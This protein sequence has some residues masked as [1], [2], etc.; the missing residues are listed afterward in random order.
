MPEAK[1]LDYA[2]TYRATDLFIN[3]LKK[4]MA[5]VAYADAEKIFE[6]IESRNRILPA[7]ILNELI[8]KISLFPY[9]YVASIMAVIG[10]NDTFLKYFE[11][12]N[13]R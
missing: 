3:D 13:A 2:K 8:T 10:R 12:V 4:V 5:N 1:V 7:G 11:P 9:K 6:M